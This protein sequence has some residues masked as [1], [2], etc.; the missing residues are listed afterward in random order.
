MS[1]TTTE[2]VVQMYRV[3]IKATPEAIWEAITSPE[4][5]ERYGYPGRNEY[6]LR[7]GGAFRSVMPAEMQAMGIPE[8]GV[9]GEVIECDPP[10]LLVQTWRFL[11]EPA[12]EAEGF[13]RVTWEIHPEHGDFTRLTVTHDV[14]DAPIAAAML[15]G[16]EPLEQGGGGWNWILSTLKTELELNR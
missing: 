2:T 7:P 11:F 13:R 8:V 1:Q 10:R 5:T 9:D 12:Q 3:Y 16:S 4:W 14:T 6:D 15:G